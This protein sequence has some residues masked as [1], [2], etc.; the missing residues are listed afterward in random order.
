[1][2]I[3]QGRA[4]LMLCADLCAIACRI[5]IALGMSS[6]HAF[7]FSSRAL[8]YFIQLALLSRCSDPRTPAQLTSPGV[9]H[10]AGP[11]LQ[12][13]E[14][15]TCA[16]SRGSL[17]H[18]SEEKAQALLRIQVTACESASMVIEV[19]GT[20]GGELGK[21]DERGRMRYSLLLTW[22][23]GLYGPRGPLIVSR[24]PFMVHHACVP[25]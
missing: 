12:S 17:E 22:A 24:L 16:F 4:E 3:W 15:D 5:A 19:F 23:N 14:G 1:M 13:W 21:L 9:F 20:L 11:P 18:S 25:P 10:P 6:N 8:A 7:Q 2:V